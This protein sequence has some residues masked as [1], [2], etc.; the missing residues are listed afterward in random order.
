[1]AARRLR[2][3]AASASVGK[4]CGKQR[5]RR[6]GIGLAKSD[7]FGEFATPKIGCGLW[8]V[9]GEPTRDDDYLHNMD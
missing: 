9:F 2:S 5:E 8:L 4:N 7:V 6:P 1:M 3:V